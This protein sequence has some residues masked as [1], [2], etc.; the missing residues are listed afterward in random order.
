MRTNRE[1]EREVHMTLP[2]DAGNSKQH[3]AAL[4][5]RALRQWHTELEDRV[6]VVTGGARG[7]GRVMAEGLLRAGARVV[8]ADKTWKGSEDFQESLNSSDRSLA[9]EMDVTDE[10]AIDAGL[11]ATLEKFR[12]VDVL[13]NNAG[14]VSETWFAPSGHVRTL[15]TTDRDWEAMFGVNVFGTLKVIRR[16]SAPML[17]RRN[18]SILNIVSSGVLT[19]SIGGGFFGARPWS[20]EMPYQATKAALTAVTFY[21]AQEISSEGVRVNALMPGH[22]RASWFDK[23]ARA[24]QQT[25]DVY[26]MRPLTADHVL[27]LVFFLSAQPGDSFEPAS[28]RL[29]HTPDWNYDHGYGDVRVWGDYDLPADLDTQYRRLE[30]AMPDYW[31]AGLA[32][33]PF[34]VERL[35]YGITMEKLR[36][37]ESGNGGA[38]SGGIAHLA[39]PSAE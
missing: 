39:R 37:E 5:E 34:D 33:A 20:E 31:R 25:G 22:T 10:A 38:A 21:L 23:T 29:Y 15:D 30:T 16:F 3:Q 18:G 19:T 26:A 11:S 28:G 17:E 12:V 9:I 1:C 36:S 2:V 32:R 7:L 6:V 13:I 4:V 14:L 35:A 24:F 8:C 27:P